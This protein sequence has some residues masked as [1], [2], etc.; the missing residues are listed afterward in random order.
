VL[1]GLGPTWNPGERVQVYTSALWMALSIPLTWLLHDPIE[2]TWLLSAGLVGWTMAMLWLASGRRTLLW[3]ALAAAWCSSKSVR[4]YLCSGLETPLVMAAVATAV[5]LPQAWPRMSARGLAALLAACLLV[6]HDLL[7]LLAPLT[8]QAMWAQVRKPDASWWVSGQGWLRAAA[9]GA[10]PLIAWSAWSWLYYGSPVPNTALAK[11]VDHWHGTDQALHYLQFM[12]HFDPW[13]YALMVAALGAAWALRSPLLWPLLFGLGLFTAYLLRVGA[14]YMAGRFF[15]GPITLSVFILARVL[16]QALASPSTHTPLNA[17]LNGLGARVRVASCL[18]LL[19]AFGASTWMKEHPS[20]FVVPL[21]IF[22]HGIADERQYYWGTTDL[23][24]LR[25]GH[26]PAFY[27]FR[28]NGEAIASAMAADP[29][30]GPF[31]VCNIGMTGYF[32]PRQAYIIDPLALSDRFLAGLP[33]VSATVRV[34]HFERPVPR[35]YLASRLSGRNQFSDP[36]LAA[37]LSDVKQV[38]NGPLWDGQRLGA[39]WRLSTGA[40]RQRM[41]HWQAGDGGGPMVLPT[42]TAQ[43]RAVGC[44]GGVGKVMQASLVGGQVNLKAL[45]TP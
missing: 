33:P 24:T 16:H 2:A 31:L 28:R 8:V 9:I 22:V 43:E 26:L 44:L 15:I 5:A 39:I 12:Q 36:V 19:T 6:R 34:G 29:H 38:L 27:G 42:A 41:L 7:L 1:A 3:L 25:G 14:D 10:L 23:A 35:D 32:A 21:P 11:I 17:W 13:A 20:T 40:Y 18:A 4:D 30:A 37:Y 45:P